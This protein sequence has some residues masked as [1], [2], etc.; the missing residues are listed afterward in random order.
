[1]LS[2]YQNADL[3]YNLPIERRWKKFYNLFKELNRKYKIVPRMDYFSLG[4]FCNKG[5]EWQ[6]L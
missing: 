5:P 4:L 6:V 1:V 3:I 2:A